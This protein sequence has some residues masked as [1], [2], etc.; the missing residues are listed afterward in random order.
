[1]KTLRRV[2]NF[3]LFLL[4]A[5]PLLAQ[6]GEGQEY[7]LSGGDQVAISV[8]GEADLAISQRIDE[9]G[10]IVMPL[11]GEVVLTGMSVREAEEYIERRFIDEDFL[12][13]PE[14][15]VQLT[16]SR[17]RVFH[18]FG[19]VNS[20]GMKQFPPNRSTLSVIQAISLAGGLTQFAKSTEVRITRRDEDGKET[21]YKVNFRDI[22]NGRNRDEPEIEILPG[23]IIV[24]PERIL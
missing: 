13:K 8:F 22:I 24:V 19:E 17:S 21:I 16:G 1:M 11:L 3:F 23:D 4:V 12:V 18:I 15:T 14:V 2:R 6:T 20:T 5:V 9:S 7:R 10:K